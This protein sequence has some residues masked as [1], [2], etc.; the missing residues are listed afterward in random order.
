MNKFKTL[1]AV[2]AGALFI[3]SGLSSCTL[4]EDRFPCPCYLNVSFTDKEA[5]RDSVAMLGW[6]TAEVFDEKVD[7]GKCDPYWVK[8][9]RKGRFGFSASCG[10]VL[11]DRTG[12]YIEIKPG[13]QSDSLYAFHDDI[14]AEGDM[15]Y[16][17]VT[18]HKQFCTVFLDIMKSESRMRD[19]VFDVSGNTCGFDLLNFSPMDGPFS[20]RPDPVVAGRIVSFR[21]PRQVDDSMTVTISMVGE[22]GK[23]ERLGE[24]P[25][26]RY[27]V[28]TGYDWNAVDLQDVYVTINLVLG[29]IIIGVDG[30]EDGAVFTFVEQ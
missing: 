3:V 25:L 12:H 2:A 23:L 14:V 30:W 5:I 8:P 19:F 17:K 29:Q 10:A 9:V 20:F 11:E 21:I 28:R 18:F 1:I 27:I 6:S 15:V 7:A 22:D 4:K 26:G 13:N 16:S 24:F